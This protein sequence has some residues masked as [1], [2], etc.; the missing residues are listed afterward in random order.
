[1]SKP[2]YH[3][4]KSAVKQDHSN[5]PERINVLCA[6]EIISESSRAFLRSLLMEYNK[7]G[8]LTK[9]Q[10]RTMEDIE[11]SLGSSAQQ[12]YKEWIE[13]FG[14][15]RH[16]IMNIC[17]EYYKDSD[18]YHQL[19]NKIHI[20]K[21]YI[22]PE[23]AYRSMCENK[24]A[25]RV[26]H[27]TLS[28]PFYEVGQVVQVRKNTRTNM[29][30]QPGVQGIVIKIAHAPV[31]SPAKGAKRYLILPFGQEKPLDIE[32]RFLKKVLTKDKK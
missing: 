10:Y 12:K 4:Y 7:K 19:A 29:E 8:G 6:S 27:A 30:F 1:M 11:M 16:T 23:S 24:Y 17:A 9:A 32:E 25:K 5:I 21:N 14:E 22:P 28:E 26:V 2:W 13:D 3:N 20:D 15:E 18:Y 31:K